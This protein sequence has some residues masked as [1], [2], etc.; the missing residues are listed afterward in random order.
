MLILESIAEIS[1]KKLDPILRDGMKGW[2]RHLLAVYP[3][4]KKGGFK[5]LVVTCFY[6]GVDYTPKPPHF[7]RLL[8]FMEVF[9]ES[10]GKGREGLYLGNSSKCVPILRGSARCCGGKGKGKGG[11]SRM[12]RR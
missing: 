10:K 9:T 2:T 3:V 11:E 5:G 8:Q 4:A 6:P 7:H 1:Y 12:A